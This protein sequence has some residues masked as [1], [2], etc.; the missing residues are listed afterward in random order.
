MLNEYNKYYAELNSKAMLWP[1]EFLVRAILGNSYSLRTS[2]YFDKALDL[3]FGDGR[4]IQLIKSKYKTVHGMEISESICKAARDKFKDSLFF[5]GK[6]HQINQPELTYDLVVAVHSI[7]YCDDANILDHFNEVFR[8]LNKGGRFIFSI[9]KNDSYLI[10][11]DCDNEE[12]CIVKND[13]LGIREG[14]RLKYYSSQSKLTID[15]FTSGFKNICIGMAD[16][17]WWGIRESCW[18]VSCSK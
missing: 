7:Y 18:I 12:Y 14:V 2:Q 6:S 8:V 5:V 1:T 16:N 17:D 11:M 4:N 13:P 9:P 10:N 3:G 15:L